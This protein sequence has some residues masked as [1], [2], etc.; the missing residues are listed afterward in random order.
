MAHHKSRH[1][2]VPGCGRL[3]SYR[4]GRIEE[5]RRMKEKDEEQEGRGGKKRKRESGH[6]SFL[7]KKLSPKTVHC[8]WSPSSAM[9]VDFKESRREGRKEKV[10]K[11]GKRKRERMVKNFG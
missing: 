10:W 3:C 4:L 1:T 2:L 9:F 5:R 11:K 7:A 6:L 8:S